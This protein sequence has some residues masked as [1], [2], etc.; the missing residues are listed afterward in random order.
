MVLTCY[1][2]RSREEKWTPERESMMKNRKMEVLWSCAEDEWGEPIQTGS[3]RTPEGSRRRARLKT[4]GGGP[5]EGRTLNGAGGRRCSEC[6]RAEWRRLSKKLYSIS[7]YQALQVHMST[8]VHL[9]QHVQLHLS[10]VNAF[11]LM[12]LQNFIQHTAKKYF[13]PMLTRRY[14]L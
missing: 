9:Q 8:H 3:I 10:S 12:E 1:R 2:R 13:V 5:P 14:R 6:C 4:P 7:F 11:K